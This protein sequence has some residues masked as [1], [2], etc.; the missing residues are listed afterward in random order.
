MALTSLLALTLTPDAVADGAGTRALISGVL[1]ATRAFDGC[2]GCEVV[3]DVED[4]AHVVVVERWDSLEHDDAYRAWRRTP[5]GASRLGEVL[6]GPPRLTRFTA[7]D[8]V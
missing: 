7:A 6:A 4:P 5:D 3:V 1:E 8:G 2:R